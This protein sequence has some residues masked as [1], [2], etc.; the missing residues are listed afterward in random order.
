MPTK[1][2]CY[3]CDKEAVG[4][5]S[6]FTFDE[7]GIDDRDGNVY[8]YTCLECGATYEVYVESPWRLTEESLPEYGQKVLAAI[9]PTD[10]IILTY[11]KSIEEP[12]KRVIKAWM[13]VPKYKENENDNQRTTASAETR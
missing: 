3:I 13:P 5:D 8:C 7:Y 12:F 2:K 11:S 1:W 9:K 4:L 10:S 6:E